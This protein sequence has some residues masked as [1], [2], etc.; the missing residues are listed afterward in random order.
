VTATA[1]PV[2]RITPRVRDIGASLALHRLLG[3]VIDWHEPAGT[4]PVAPDGSYREVVC[5][6]PHGR[7]VRL[8]HFGPA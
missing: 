7:L 8:I 5:F 1:G 4:A 6:D 3:P 2:K